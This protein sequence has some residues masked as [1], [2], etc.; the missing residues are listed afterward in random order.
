MFILSD[1]YSPPHD[2]HR[3]IPKKIEGRHQTWRESCV[4][5]SNV[6]ESPPKKKILR[7]NILPPPI[8][9]ILYNLLMLIIL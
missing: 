3:P 7:C 9:E 6:I 1:L 4:N 8:H 2:P 5:F